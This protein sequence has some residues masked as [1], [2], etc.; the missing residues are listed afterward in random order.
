MIPFQESRAPIVAFGELLLRLAAPRGELLLQTPDLRVDVGGA[1]ANVAVSLARMGHSVRMVSTIPDNPLGQHARDTMRYH[2]VDARDIGFAPGRMGLYFLTPGAVNRPAEI[3]YDRVGSAFAERAAA[4]YRWADLLQGA[5]WLHISGVT[6]A[7]GAGAASAALDAAKAARDMGIRV[8]FDGNYRASLWQA[9]GQFGTAIL[10]A[11]VSC[12]DLAFI[13]ERDIALL[14]GDPRL[15]AGLRDEAVSA[16]FDAFPHLAAIAAT[17]RVQHSVDSHSLSATFA[18]RH[19]TSDAPERRIDG[20]VD[21]IGTGD[22]FAAG[23]L[24][25]AAS[26]WEAADIVNYGLACACL[27]H[28]L[29]GDLH[30]LSGT[31]IRNLMEGSFDVRR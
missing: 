11:I 21:R 3:V 9:R 22:A 28:G 27:K 5:G 24:H 18:T 10:A 29:A 14:L 16:A 1:E 25:G 8:S 4:S 19:G 31:R 23:V 2:G 30:A 17:T 6:P 7:V 15:G 20:I 13:D 12:A 26:G